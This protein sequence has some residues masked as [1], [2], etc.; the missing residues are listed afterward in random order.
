MD[1]RSS[2]FQHSDAFP[3]TDQPA[4]STTN[5]ENPY[6]SSQDIAQNPTYND[7]YKANPFSRFHRYGGTFPDGIQQPV[8]SIDPRSL[9]STDGRRAY[10]QETTG[11]HHNIDVLRTPADQF[12]QGASQGS[13]RRDVYPAASSSRDTGHRDTGHTQPAGSPYGDVA[14]SQEAMGPRLKSPGGTTYAR[15]ER[16]L[17]EFVAGPGTYQ[18]LDSGAQQK[19]PAEHS[20][21]S[22]SVS[23][24]ETGTNRTGQTIDKLNGWTREDSPRETLSPKEIASQVGKAGGQA[25]GKASLALRTPEQRRKYASLA[26]KASAAK[27]TQRRDGDGAV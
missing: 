3:R 4:A 16:T 27:R 10:P 2:A 9:T 6:G 5:R 13:A 15:G 14:V 19:R 11:P 18:T 20:L 1:R 23:R 24:L 26:G 8:P 21:S 12:V 25:G 17:K 7:A 22:S